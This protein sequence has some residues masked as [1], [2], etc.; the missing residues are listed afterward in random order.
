MKALILMGGRGERLRPLTDFRPKPML[1]VM[2]RPVVERQ[3]LNLKKHGVTEVV[4]SVGY[5]WR[6]IKKHFGD[7]SA[8]GVKITYS[9]EN[10]LMGTGGA[11]ALASRYIGGD[12]L[13]INGDI[14]ADFD[15]S[16]ILNLRR[17]RILTSG[18]CPV[19]I[20]VVTVSDP[21]KYGAVVVGEGKRILRFSEKKKGGRTKTINA[22]CY[23]LPF[24]FIRAIPR[25]VK[26]SLE[27]D[28][29]EKCAFPMFAVHHHWGWRDIGTIEDYIKANEFSDGKKNA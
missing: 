6:E 19:L 29:F 12:A 25:G 13:V 16:E 4:L 24:D 10:E 26:I 3:I 28:I 20:S 11:V 17:L 2:G 23:L 21:W 5:K 7:G 9:I 15:I 27:K 8:L 14:V 18:V 22:G 1:P